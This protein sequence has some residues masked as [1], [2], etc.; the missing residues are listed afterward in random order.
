MDG[1]VYGEVNEDM[2]LEFSDRNCE[3]LFLWSIFLICFV[4][5]FCKI[6][7]GND[8]SVCGSLIM[9]Q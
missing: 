1:I 7:F 5:V 8:S 9:H 4:L 2:F 6:I 3:F